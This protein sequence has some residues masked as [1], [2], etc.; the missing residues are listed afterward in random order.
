[1]KYYKY[2]WN[3]LRGDKFD[4]W[5]F[6]LWYFEIGKDE[7]PSR[8]IEIYENG[9]ILKYSENNLKDEFGFLGDQKLNLSEFNGIECSKIE[10]EE[11]WEK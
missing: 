2:K 1:M 11:N 10:F 7:F 6:S 8:Q 5:G 4:I 9:K 3:E